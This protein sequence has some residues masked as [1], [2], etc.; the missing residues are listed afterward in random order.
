MKK[1][2]AGIAMS[3][4]M[5]LS[6]CSGGGGNSSAPDS[7][8]KNESAASGEKVTLTYGIWDKNQQPAMEEI[9]KKF[10]ESHPSVDVK[11]ELTPY[12]QYF[13]KLETA[14]TGGS[15]PDVF[16]MNGSHIIKYGSNDM[17]LPLNDLI[18]ADGVDLGN[19][20]K[21]L[22]DLYTVDGVAYGLPKDFDT[23][24]LWYNKKLFDEA[25]IPYPDG[26]WDWNK[27]KETAKKLTNPAK[28]VWGFAGNLG[29]EQATYYN[30]IF[31]NGGYVIA[32]DKK[33][34]GFDKP[35]TIGGLQFWSDMIKEKVSPTFAQMTETSPANLFESGKLAMI[36]DGAWMASEFS[37]N[38]YTRDK[39]DVAPLPKGKENT[40]V[41]HGLSNVI[42]A[43]TKHPKEAW[44]FVKFLGSK[45]AAEIQASK[46]AAI[47]AFNGTQDAWV[48]SRPNLNLQVF[49]DQAATAKPYPVSKDTSK[50]AT[51]SAETLGKAWAGEISV[52]DAAKEI[53]KK[54]N[55]LLAQE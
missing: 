42:A 26:T 38:E 37:E 23:I 33:S 54:M 27:L 14:A 6:A 4:A 48:K 47:P 1:R 51:V 13:T 40:S 43:N 9:V 55:E 34:S 20:P 22:V 16:W 19:Y 45:E 8:A 17:L 15:L 35:E 46:A 30:T 31:Q 50:W 7:S 25:N 41:I 49:I 18:R 3:L 10:E 36:T 29:D 5:V 44:E 21:A 39:V 24:G 11:I 2:L 28:G 32:E 12:K 52:E 53:A